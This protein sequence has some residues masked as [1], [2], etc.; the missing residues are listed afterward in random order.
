MFCRIGVKKRKFKP[1]P[2]VLVMIDARKVPKK[3]PG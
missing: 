1:V 3:S 2:D